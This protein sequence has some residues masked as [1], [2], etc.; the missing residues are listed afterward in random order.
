MES[1]VGVNQFSL[2]DLRS[3]VDRLNYSFQMIEQA[4]SLDQWNPLQ[5]MYKRNDSIRTFHQHSRNKYSLS[6]DN[7]LVGDLLIAHPLRQLANAWVMAYSE[8]TYSD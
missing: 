5:K 2:V 4:L 6:T 3:G 7:T 8:M 1:K